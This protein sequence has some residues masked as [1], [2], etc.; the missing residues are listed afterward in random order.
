[1]TSNEIEQHRAIW[2]GHESEL[3][4]AIAL[5]AGQL[6]ARA[7]RVEASCR[8]GSFEEMIDIERKVL[9][10]MRYGREVLGDDHM[11]FSGLLVDAVSTGTVLPPIA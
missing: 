8:G 11:E 7:R 9:A 4:V 3:S 6:M 10:L 2:R 1:M 5:Y